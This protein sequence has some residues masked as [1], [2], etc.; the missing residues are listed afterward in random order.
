[1]LALDF[2]IENLFF[3]FSNFLLQLVVVEAQRVSLFPQVGVLS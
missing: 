3:H 2:H 1:L